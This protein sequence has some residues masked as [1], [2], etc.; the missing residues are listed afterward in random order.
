MLRIDIERLTHSIKTTIACILGLLLAK[1]TGFSSGQWVVITIVVVMCAQLYVGSVTQKAYL[2][3]LGT[4]LGC[5]FA[6]FIIISLGGSNLAI[7]LA[8]SLSSFIFS[9][10]ATGPID[11]STTGTLGAVTTIIIMLGQQPTLSFAAERF[12]EISVGIFIATLVSQFVLPIH[13]RDHLRR[14]QATTLEQLR[15]YYTIVMT[16]L[17]DSETIDV[18]DLEENIVKSLF[19]QRQLAKES[20]RERGLS[21]DTTHF[22]Q[23]FYCERDILR[24]VSYMHNA[25]VSVKKSGAPFITLPSLRHFNDT[26]LQ[27]L[28]TIIDAIHANIPPTSHIHV[29]SLKNLKEELQKDTTISREELIHIDGFLFSAEILVNSI[30]K[31][32]NLYHIP[33]YQAENSSIA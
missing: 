33:I 23:Y 5:L 2:R 24:S 8:I 25:L 18:S 3:F 14:T 22:M 30:I 9:Y 11:L 6:A 12:L 7:I 10:I 20:L 15:D 4:T 13:A 31:L 29:P 19:K 17:T 28:T 26:I 16:R 27:L 21:F 32:A 1:L